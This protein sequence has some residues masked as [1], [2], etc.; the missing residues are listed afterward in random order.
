MLAAHLHERDVGEARLPPRAAPPRRRRRGRA[1]RGSLAATSSG[2]TNWLAPEK[3]IGVGRSALT[4]QPPANQR[5]CSWARFTAAS[6]EGSQQIGICPTPRAPDA[7]RGVRHGVPAVDEVLLRLHGDEVVGQRRQ[8]LEP[9]VAAD[10]HRRARPPCS[11][12]SQMR[13]ESTSKCSPR[14]VTSSPVCSSRMT[15]DRLD[16]HRPDGSPRRASP[17]PTTCSL[18]FSPLP[19]PRVNRPSA[20]ICR[21]AAFCATTAGW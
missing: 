8:L 20:R 10:G 4:F 18:R 19:R 11:G 9:L 14:K 15:C 5:N 21:V 16:E 6:S 7:D 13:A 12:T 17:P 3:P 1:R 2:R